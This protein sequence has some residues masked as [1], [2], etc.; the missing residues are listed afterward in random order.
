MLAEQ[1]AKKVAKNIE[2]DNL[3]TEKGV[4]DEV[5]KW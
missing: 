2:D 4:D 1:E 5:V 3:A